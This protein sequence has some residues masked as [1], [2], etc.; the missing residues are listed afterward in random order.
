M[1]NGCDTWQVVVAKSSAEY[2]TV[3]IAERFN[4]LFPS[5]SMKTG[6]GDDTFPTFIASKKMFTLDEVSI[7]TI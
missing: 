2:C 1:A 3:W 4:A 6:Y 5:F 7:R